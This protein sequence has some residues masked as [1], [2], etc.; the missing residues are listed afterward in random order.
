MVRDHFSQ[1]LETDIA[2]ANGHANLATDLGA[3]SLAIAEVVARLMEDGYFVD[4][5]VLGQAA[6]LGQFLA[7]V[8]TDGEVS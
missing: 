3:D 5:R 6:T 1:V 7:G 8:R 2:W 4:D